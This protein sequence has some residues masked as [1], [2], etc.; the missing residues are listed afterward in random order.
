MLYGLFIPYKTPLLAGIISGA[1]TGLVAGMVHL[2]AYVLNT[3][4][5][6]YGLAAFLGGS[7]S[8]YIA[9]GI[10]IAVSL[11]SGFLI[12]MFTKLGEKVWK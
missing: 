12:M 7:S 11:I 1:L 6:I 10:T 8:N 4:N 9:L 2:T 5:G 3:S